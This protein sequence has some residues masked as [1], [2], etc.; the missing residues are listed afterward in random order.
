MSDVTEIRNV[1][2]PQKLEKRVLALV[3]LRERMSIPPDVIYQ[4]V[5]DPLRFS[6]SLKFIHFDRKNQIFSDVHGWFPVDCIE[7]LEVLCEC[8][9]KGVAVGQ[10]SIY[11]VPTKGPELAVIGDGY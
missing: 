1:L 6:P 7:I 8:D 9:E 11:S 3:Q 10:D 5:L 4:V 2:D